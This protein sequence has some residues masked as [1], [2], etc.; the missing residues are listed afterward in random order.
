M[1]TK[2]IDNKIIISVKTFGDPY[3]AIRFNDVLATKNA[4]KIIDANSYEYSLPISILLVDLTLSIEFQV[5]GVQDSFVEVE[6]SNRTLRWVPY[7]GD[8]VTERSF[9]YFLLYALSVQDIK[10][11]KIELRPLDIKTLIS[12]DGKNFTVKNKDNKGDI[13]SQSAASEQDERKQLADSRWNMPQ[14][15]QIS[16]KGGDSNDGV[17]VNE[18]SVYGAKHLNKGDDGLASKLT[19]DLAY[20]VVKV[21][22]ATDRNP[23]KQWDSITYG[24]V[25]GSNLLFGE[26]L[27]SVPLNKKMGEIPRPSRL[28]LESENPTKHIMLSK[29]TEMSEDTF[30]MSIDTS[31]SNSEDNE[32]FVFIHGYNVTFK[33][34]ILR[35]GQIAFDISFEGAPIV[36]SWPSVCTLDGYWADEDNVKRTTTYLYHLLK[37][38]S[39]RTTAKKV[40]LIAHSMGNRALADALAQFYD[41]GRKVKFNQIIMAAPD[42]DA[43]IFIR[44]IAPKLINSH[45]RLTLYASSKDKALAMSRRL[46]KNQMLRLGETHEKIVCIDGMDTVDASSIDTNLLGHGYFAETA[47]LLYDIFLLT[48]HNLAPKQRNLRPQATDKGNCWAF[49]I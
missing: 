46:R 22:Y 1:Q 44:Q 38:I 48:K 15:P 35:A 39:S 25:R 31:I 19:N 33:E 32:A 3:F 6:I 13:R 29:I 40:H 14:D 42:I 7:S 23:I 16:A 27:V 28:L 47:A 10:W 45:Q 26:C 17:N 36:Y 43:E 21:F 18:R 49:K 2:I 11:Y 4:F 20:Q 5:S 34:A 30:Y 41:E 37:M 8:N 9:G 12:S 24:N